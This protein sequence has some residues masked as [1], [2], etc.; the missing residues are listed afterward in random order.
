MRYF[1]QYRLS[2]GTFTSQLVGTTQDAPLASS[3]EG[4]IEGSFD[5]ERQ[6]VETPQADFGAGIDGLHMPRVVDYQAPQPSPDHEWNDESRRWEL[7]ATARERADRHR[8]AVARIEQLERSQ[9][10]A[11]RE[12]A[13]GIKDGKER[14][15]AIDDEI[16]RSRALLSAATDR[17]AGSERTVDSAAP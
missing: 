11:L 9:P 8:D 5:H 12:A 15:Q 7:I 4:W 3:T 6:R 16:A 10:R 14:L 2:D 13:L 17:T 1:S